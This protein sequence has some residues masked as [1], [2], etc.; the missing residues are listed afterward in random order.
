MKLIRFQAG[1]VHEYLDF[2]I[3]FNDDVNFIAG[4]NG[5]GKTSALNIIAALLAPSLEDLGKISFG[6]SVLSVVTDGG[7]P[8]SIRAHQIKEH[9]HV[10]VEGPDALSE[11]SIVTPLDELKQSSDHAVT[12]KFRLTPVFKFISNLP[13]PMYLSLDRRFI[14]EVTPYDA[15][16]FNLSKIWFDKASDN[17]S[18][19]DIG[20][21]DALALISKKSAEIKDRQ[22]IEDRSLRN[23]IILDSFYIDNTDRGAMVLPDGKSLQQLKAKQK[24]IKN[25]LISL[26]F[27]NEELSVMYDKFFENLTSILKNVLEVFENREKSSAALS[28]SPSHKRKSIDA[29]HQVNPKATAS[30]NIPLEHSRVLATWFSN[31]HQMARI[32]RLIN[33]IGEYERIKSDVYEPLKKFVN[34]VNSFLAQTKKKISITNRGE[35]KIFISDVEKK[36]TVLSSGER[37]ILIMLAHLSLNSHLPKSGV[38]IVDEPELS[39]HIAWQ[40]M[41]LEAVQAAGPELQ[42]ILATHSPAI[43]GGRKKYYIPL[44]GGI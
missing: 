9:L 44:N 6:F 24:T 21:K 27:K 34:L 23:K 42:I 31:S 4:L 37:Q 26:D 32:D 36:L 2:D 13:S 30:I 8:F 1:G 7:M 25:T 33:L 5:S 19:A 17:D 12:N 40:D 20:M 41:F 29:A 3:R 22:T 35:V 18:D 14:K 16:P 38:F 43:I 10:W 39:L 11:E 15:S 28:R